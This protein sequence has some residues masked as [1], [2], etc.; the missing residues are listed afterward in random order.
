MLDKFEPSENGYLYINQDN[1]IKNGK[2]IK[3]FKIGYAIDME[4]RLREYK[5]GNFS[6]IA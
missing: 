5:V 1:S 4:K 2:E 6:S 3:C